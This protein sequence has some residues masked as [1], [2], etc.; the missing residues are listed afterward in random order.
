[1]HHTARE[2]ALS[3]R[4][5]FWS[6]RHQLHQGQSEAPSK[7]VDQE[8]KV[9]A[10]TQRRW[11]S[12]PWGLSP[13]PRLEHK[14]KTYESFPETPC[15]L[16]PGPASCTA[17]LGT[18]K[19]TDGRKLHFLNFLSCWG[20]RREQR[21]GKPARGPG[22]MGKGLPSSGR[23][24]SPAGRELWGLR[25]TAHCSTL[26]ARPI[27]PD[28]KFPNCKGTALCQIACIYSLT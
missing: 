13:C 27:N 14:E 28:D 21:A 23:L 25:S 11:Q 7:Q 17:G 6:P 2:P 1:M 8:K 15:S 10:L 19:V 22:I 5:L 26:R 4:Q 24:P 9:Q 12:L 3:S 18:C 20:G 16:V